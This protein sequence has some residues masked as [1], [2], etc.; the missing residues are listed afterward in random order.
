MRYIAARRWKSLLIA[1]IAVAL[2]AAAYT[3]A[4]QFHRFFLTACAATGPAPESELDIDVQSVDL[5][6]FYA[7]LLEAAVGLS[8]E[9]IATASYDGR[10]YPLY[11]IGPQGYA[12]NDSTLVIAGVHGN[13]ISGSLAAVQILETMRTRPP[14]AAPIHL[15]A[16]ANPVGLGHGSRYN[17]Q[18]C[19][20]N[21][22]FAA[23]RTIE[24]DAIRKAI[25]QLRPRLVVALHE[26]P[27]DGLFV[28]GTQITPVATLNRLVAQLEAQPIPLATEN[29]L[30]VGLPT[31][32]VMTEG[33]FITRAK[34]WLG[35]YSAG[36]YASK[37]GIPLITVEIPWGWP[38]MQQRVRAQTMSVL[39]A[40]QP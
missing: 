20:I 10:Q 31:P 15:L 2:V 36:E 34:G 17:S 29:N 19:D 24:A 7:R 27:Q 9:Q 30:G 33:A 23:F 28:I 18:G 8:V 21:R 26:G 16:P 39:A 4:R 3:P 1:G 22:D 11:L 32:G 5:E 37:L 35:I 25:D 40:A 6:S 13:E 38:D 12:A 14:D